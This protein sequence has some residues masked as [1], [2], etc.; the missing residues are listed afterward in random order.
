MIGLSAGIFGV[1]GA[2][3]G[4]FLSAYDLQRRSIDYYPA[5]SRMNRLAPLDRASALSTGVFMT[6]C[7]HS[8]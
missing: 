4:A 5:P 7:R 8:R 1:G 2:V 3:R 6:H